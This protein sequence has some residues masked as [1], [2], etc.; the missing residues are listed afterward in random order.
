MVNLYFAFSPRFP[1]LPCTDPFLLPQKTLA[2]GYIYKV[3]THSCCTRGKAY[4]TAQTPKQEILGKFKEL[5]TRKYENAHFSKNI[6]FLTKLEV[7]SVHSRLYFLKCG[8]IF[9]FD[10]S[11]CIQALH[12]GDV[13]L[14]PF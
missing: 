10:C 5:N 13:K 6:S 8:S 11:I 9:S 2:T 3:H 1:P 7:S 4:H 12:I 14:V